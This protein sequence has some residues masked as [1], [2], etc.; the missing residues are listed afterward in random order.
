M[1]KFPGYIKA[2]ATRTDTGI[3]LTMRLRT[4][5]PSMLGLLWSAIGVQPRLLKPAI[6]LWA[7][8]MSMRRPWDWYSADWGAS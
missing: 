4:W 6:V 7:W 2:K 5:H 1:A 8:V 3:T